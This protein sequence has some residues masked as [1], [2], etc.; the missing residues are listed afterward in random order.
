M[1]QDL[2]KKLWSMS[3]SELASL[4]GSENYNVIS[5][6]HSKAVIY[7]SGLTEEQASKTT[8]EEIIK[9]VE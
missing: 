8:A 3:R 6:V 2:I 1:K 4:I 9:G 5:R 7:A